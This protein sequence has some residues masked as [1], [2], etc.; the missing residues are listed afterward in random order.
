LPHT[1]LLGGAVTIGQLVA[2]V[3]SGLI[4]TPHQETKKKIYLPN[5][6]LEKLLIAQ[7]PLMSSKYLLVQTSTVADRATDTSVF[8]LSVHQ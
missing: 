2:D 6:I 5:G 7:A 8:E 1:Q 3:P 4:L